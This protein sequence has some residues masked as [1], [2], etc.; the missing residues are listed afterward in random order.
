MR[1]W[2]AIGL[3]ISLAM[4]LG[5]C[6]QPAGSGPTATTKATAEEQAL[7]GALSGDT[8]SNPHAKL[9]YFPA[10]G[11][12]VS[13]DLAMKLV[14]A[15]LG[16]AGDKTTFERCMRQKMTNAFDDSGEG[17]KHC[18]SL[19]GIEAFTDCLVIGNL[20]LDL[21]Q[22]LDVAAP[23]PA[24][25]WNDKKTMMKALVTSMVS[26]AI[27]ACGAEQAASGAEACAGQ[28]FADKLQIPDAMRQ[29]CAA[30]GA[31]KGYDQ[32]SCF[33]EAVT[34]IYLREHVGRISSVSA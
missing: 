1:N 8:K 26:G 17:D 28:W 5:A 2:R 12:A 31:S 10:E 20:V 23:V 9:K 32:G 14:T 3:A 27:D 21:R 19:S 6:Q 34:V 11:D 22:R 29:H 25:F 16:N 13:A 4:L 24:D 7:A 15:C 18:R 33:A 30:A